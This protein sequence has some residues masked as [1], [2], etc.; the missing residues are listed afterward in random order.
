MP[1]A[2][3]FKYWYE[4]PFMLKTVTLVYLIRGECLYCFLKLTP[5]LQCFKITEDEVT[6]TVRVVCM[7]G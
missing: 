1:A 5:I 7:D 3:L 6:C 2:L 4:N